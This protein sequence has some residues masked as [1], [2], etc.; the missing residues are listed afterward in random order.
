MLLKDKNGGESGILMPL[1]SL[2]SKF[3]IGSLGKESYK[4]TDFLQASEQRYWQLLPLVPLGEGNSPYKSV[5]CFAGEILYIDPDMLV[6]NGLLAENELPEDGI[7]DRTDYKAARKI[8]LPLLRLAAER[9]NTK[10][11]EYQL[12]VAKNAYWLDDFALFS[13]ITEDIPNKS[14]LEIPDDLKYRFPE[15]IEKFRITHREKIRFYKI[16]QYFFYNQFFSLRDYAHKKGIKLIGD[17]PFYISLDS[18]DVWSCPQ[19]FKIGR[20]FTPITVA[21][22]PPDRFSSSGQLWGNPI[23]DWEYHKKTDF[24]WWKSRLNFCRRLYDVIRIDHFRAFANYYAIPYGSADAKSGVWEKGS[25]LNFW[26]SIERELGKLNIIAEDLGGEEREVRELIKNTGFPD[27]RIL[28]FGFEDNIANRNLPKNYI[29]NCVCYTGTHD[30][31]TSR[32]WYA[33]APPREKLFA[34][35][36]LPDIPNAPISEKMIISAMRSKAR[37]VIIPMQDILNLPSSARMN[38][39]GTRRGNWEWRMDGNALCKKLSE[40]L[41]SI[42]GTRN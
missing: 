16:T 21:G 9:F 4:F 7:F 41:K 11:K 38:T 17:I 33:S 25:G 12:F 5:S 39:P 2:P 14:I 15:A 10:S 26:Q 6:Q 20:D 23:Y 42:S 31:D 13:A 3:G 24:A 37:L 8:K 22:V 35:R 28:Q 18:S 27:M 29:K 19:A 34:S 1:S 36:Y 40:H 32:G 30:N